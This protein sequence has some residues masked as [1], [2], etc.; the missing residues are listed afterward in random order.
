MS[1][2]SWFVV[3]MLLAAS[4]AATAAPD[5][6]RIDN[7]VFG[8][9][10]TPR[11]G[12]EESIIISPNTPCSIIGVMIYYGAGTGQD[13]VRITGD[14]SEGTIPPTQYCFPYNTLG[15]ATTDV[16]GPGWKTIMFNG[17]GIRIDGNE[18]IVVQHVMSASGP[19]WGQDNNGQSPTTSYQYDP[20][21]P[22]PNFFNIP[23][24]YYLA[25]GDYMVRLIIDNKP[26]YRKPPTWVD[27]TAEVGLPSGTSAIKSDQL[28]VVDLDADGFD[29]LC[30]AGQF[31]RNKGNGTFE[32]ITAPFAAGA[33]TAWAD[34]DNDGDV[35]CIV[36]GGFGSEKL[37]RNDGAGKFTDVTPSSGLSNNAPLVTALWLDIENDGDLDL[38]LANGRSE[39]NGNEVY[40][41]DKLWRN[42][43]DWKFTD[44]TTSS[45]V[46]KGEPAPYFDT[47][48]ASLTDY[49]NDGRTDI[50]VATYR[51]APDRLYRNNGD[52]TFTEVSKETGTQ[53]IATTQPQYFGHG[54]GSE[55]TDVNNDGNVDLIVGNLGHPD[56]RAQYSNPSLMLISGGASSNWTFTNDADFR[57]NGY[58]WHGIAFKEM[59]AGVCAADFNHD[60][61]TDVWHGQIS[62]E[63]FGTGANRPAHFYLGSKHS[64]PSRRRFDDITWESGMFIHGAWTA[65]RLDY[66][67]DGDLD[68]ICA[69]GTE[70]V[71]LF[72]NDLPKSGSSI[73][74]P[75][76]GSSITIRLRDVRQGKN[77]TGYG[78]RIVLYANGNSYTRW[79]PGTVSGGRMSQMT[80]DLHVGIPTTTIDSVVVHWP[81]NLITRHTGLK[82]HTYVE[83]TSDGKSTA[84]LSNLKPAQIYP[85]HGAIMYENEQ[86][87]WE[88]PTPTTEIEIRREDSTRTVVHLGS[89]TGTS[90][91]HSLPKDGQVYSWR[92]KSTQPNSQWTPY[93]TFSVG[94]PRPSTVL[95]FNPVN[96]SVEIPTSPNFWW[97]EA[98]Y[99]MQG[100]TIPVLYHVTVANQE[101][102][103]QRVVYVDTMVADRTLDVV[104]LPSNTP[105]MCQVTPINPVDPSF[106]V[107]GDSAVS[108]FRTYDVPGA[109]SIIFPPNNAESVTTRPRFQWSRPRTVDK[110]FEL[111]VDTLPSFATATLKR[112]SDT[113]IT[114]TP[115][116]KSGRRY[117]WRARGNNRAGN[118]FW[119]GGATFVTAGTTSVQ[120]INQQNCE[121]TS[122]ECYDL[123][124]NPIGR[125]RVEEGSEFLNSI[126]GVFLLVK[127]DELGKP[128]G[129]ELV[130]R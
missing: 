107:R 105:L 29:D 82:P 44:V 4:L 45:G 116:L 80:E 73:N 65:C 58:V 94:A 22:N 39:S 13:E 17:Q 66:D 121:P 86:F 122:I 69:S 93:W 91:K 101:T 120:D 67:R 114:W 9:T 5:T 15:L 106:F 71:K 127:C 31:F 68:L 16:T 76:A 77:R 24:I 113:S 1:I 110:G 33:P 35:D 85:S 14:A 2:R 38:F 75:A 81:G 123:R 64:I 28:S 8:S 20:V 130:I 63:A 96:G 78:A 37:W 51:L 100:A 19:R 70:R 12:W 59:N 79:L 117:Y 61:Y 53:G 21:S 34:V 27:V 118:G 104:D 89:V 60:G 50:F 126:H 99:K 111:E 49:N 109:P 95:L 112:A 40:F 46:A 54:M 124:G 128:C 115:P 23:G 32:K 3:P 84:I 43:G 26:A 25:K 48:G 92:I 55:W 102:G 83:I 98:T 10:N 88:S 97:T 56:S 52:G 11:D 42:D 129:S 7:G 72:R 41:Q 47:W 103:S 30:V 90:Y 36:A 119:S 108:R 62:Y 125:W 74:L 57:G 18:R 6:I 87:S